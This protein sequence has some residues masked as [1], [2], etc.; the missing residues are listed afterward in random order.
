MKANK[1]FVYS[2]E[3]IDDVYYTELNET[4]QIDKQGEIRIFKRIK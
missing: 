2:E 1:H 4:F 3:I